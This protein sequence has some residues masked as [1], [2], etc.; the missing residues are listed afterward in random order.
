MKIIVKENDIEGGAAAFKIFEKGIK[1]GAKVLGLATGSTPVTLYQ[2]WVKSDLNC[3]NLTSINLD[4]YV[5]L[6]PDNPQSYHYFMQKHLF[7]KKPFKK[8]YVPDGLEAAKDP[9]AAADHYN[10]IIKDNPIDIQL[11][12]IGRNGHIAFNEPGSSFD[13]VTREVKLT[14]NTIKANSRFFDN[15]DEVPKSA[16]CMGIANIMSAKKVVLMAFGKNKAH[17]IKEMIEGPVTEQVP[18]SILQKHLDVVVIIDKAA[19]SEL[20]DKYKK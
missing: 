9:Q 12:G 10:Q 7:D 6:K 15:I 16:I 17:A 18:A 13:T 11:L 1:N 4:E 3:D 20:D 2:N 5:G 14:D 19:A 8:S